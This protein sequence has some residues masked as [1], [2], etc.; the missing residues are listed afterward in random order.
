METDRPPSIA[1]IQPWPDSGFIDD[2][3]ALLGSH[4]A[5]TRI[6]FDGSARNLLRTVRQLHRAGRADVV[7]A[8]F[9]I[10]VYIPQLAVACRMWR[11]PLVIITGGVDVARMRELSFG[12]PLRPGS[13]LRIAAGLSLAHAVVP[14]SESASRQVLAIAQPRRMETIYPAIDVDFH[15]LAEGEPPRRTVLT[16]GTLGATFIKP[17]GLDIFVEAARHAPDLQFVIAG[18]VVDEAGQAL[19]AAAPPNLTVTQRYLTREELRDLYRSAAGYVQASRY[20]GFGVACAE[21]M[22]CGA[23]PVVHRAW[24]LPEVVGP[25]GHQVASLDPSA[26]V[27]PIRAT[28]IADGD[29]RRMARRRVVELFAPHLRREALFAVF[30]RL[31]PRL[32]WPRPA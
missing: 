8:W 13:R 15:T 28:L 16:V 2:D 18:R 7:L 6:E 5:V 32:S 29:A 1:L 27:A 22:A 12:L 4:A 14:F 11:C 19:L 30:A 26:Y 9:A 21:A 3:I 31:A 24:S 25:T 23:I 20:E 10:P 17:K